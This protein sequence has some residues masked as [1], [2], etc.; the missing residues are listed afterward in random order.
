MRLIQ[1]TG[2]TL[3]Q[4]YQILERIKV[5]EEV[6]READHEHHGRDDDQAGGSHGEEAG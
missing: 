5:G 4:M 2:R 3:D 1:K 6:A